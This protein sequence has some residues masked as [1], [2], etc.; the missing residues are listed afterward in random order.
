LSA[1]VLVK[2]RGSCSGG[3]AGQAFLKFFHSAARAGRNE[4]L[5]DN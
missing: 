5:G 2:S 3:S 4:R 1:C